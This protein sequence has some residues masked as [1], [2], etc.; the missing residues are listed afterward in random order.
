MNMNKE[1]KSELIY[2]FL[3]IAVGFAIIGAGFLVLEN[4]K[5]AMKEFCINKTG[6]HEGQ[7]LTINCTQ[8]H[9]KYSEYYEVRTDE[10]I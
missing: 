10:S 3:G 6:L 9:Q 2:L 8:I 7:G 5:E 1:L 4:Q